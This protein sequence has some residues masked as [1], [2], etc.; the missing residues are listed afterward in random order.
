MTKIGGVG[1]VPYVVGA[2]SGK[3]ARENGTAKDDP[4]EE[5]ACVAAHGKGV[6]GCFAIP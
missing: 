6:Q 4:S 2:A 1:W 5:Q 3:V